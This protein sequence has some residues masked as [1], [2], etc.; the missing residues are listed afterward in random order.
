MMSIEFR[1]RKLMRSRRKHTERDRQRVAELSTFM[2]LTWHLSVYM[3]DAMKK[4][5]RKERKRAFK[6]IFLKACGRFNNNNAPGKS[7]WPGKAFHKIHKALEIK[8]VTWV[9]L[10]QRA[11]E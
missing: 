10:F 11:L 5:N 7:T 8:R 4:E 6:I 9:E 2:N 3:A 1:P